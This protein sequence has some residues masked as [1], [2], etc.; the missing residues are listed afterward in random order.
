MTKPQRIMIIAGETSGDMLAADLV[1]AL[2]VELGDEGF[3]PE[4][5]GAGGTRMAEVG[6]DLIFDMTKHSVIG[7]WEVIVR[8]RKFQRLFDQLLKV[9][10]D[11]QPDL[12]ICVDFS[13][14]NRRFAAAIRERLRQRVGTFTNWHPRIVQYVSPQ[15]W[16]SR[17]DRANQM[18]H[19]FNLL[20]SI[21]PFER[22]WYAQ[23]EPRLPVK[24]VGNPI[25]D[26]Y[27][28]LPCP[29]T[30]EANALPLVVLLPGSRTGELARH[31]EPMLEAAERIVREHPVRLRA[32][33]PS[34]S[35]AEKF[36]NHPIAQSLS[37]PGGPLTIQIGGLPDA[38]Q[39]ATVAIAS[40]GTVTLECAYFGVPTVAIYKTSWLTYQ[41]G[42]RIVQVRFLAMPNLLADEAVF[43]ELIQNDATGGNIAHEALALLKDD[44]RRTV[45][46]HKLVSVVQ[47]LGQPGA[48]A[49]AAQAILQA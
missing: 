28:K 47:S 13:G 11:R 40:T 3:P 35:L 25:L 2:R 34:E 17:A 15:V 1:R 23:R 38:L 27:A 20:L 44:A 10:E 14:F 8:Y 22:D 21:L 4:F 16:A 9:A 37:K 19:E 5:F 48:S 36:K 7:L 29:L 12:I 18:V 42:K 41:I 49:R 32:I 33:L 39:Q 6:V 30:V 24:F 45:I 43:P 31:S 26:R 46:K